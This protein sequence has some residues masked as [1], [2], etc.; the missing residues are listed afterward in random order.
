MVLFKIINIVFLMGLL[1]GVQKILCLGK[2]G[3][4]LFAAM[5]FMIPYDTFLDA[6]FSVTCIYYVWPATFAVWLIYI[7]LYE[8]KGWGWKIFGL[9]CLLFSCN[10]EQM[11]IVVTGLLCLIGIKKW[12][13]GKR[14]WYPYFLILI[15]VTELLYM[16]FGPGGTNRVTVSITKYFPEF[17]MLTPLQKIDI[18][19]S[20]TMAHLLFQGDVIWLLFSGILCLVLWN[21]NSGEKRLLGCI[22]FGCSVLLGPLYPISEIL[23]PQITNITTAVQEYGVINLCNYDLRNRWIPLLFFAFILTTGLIDLFLALTEKER[24][25]GVL[26]LLLGLASRFVMGFSPTVYA[27]GNRTFYPLWIVLILESYLLVRELDPSKRS[28]VSGS[29]KLAAMFSVICL[30]SC[31]NQ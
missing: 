4:A 5:L 11:A 21:R 6:G 10:M 3:T 23:F 27:S 15:S 18:G 1:A 20:T 14:G 12:R 28:L 19:V 30:A 7:V 16:K 31:F 9:L 22:P 29:V 24:I 17:S 13:E 8:K 26:L 2:E 25:W